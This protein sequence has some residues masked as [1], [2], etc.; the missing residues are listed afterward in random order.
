MCCVLFVLFVF[1]NIRQ[2]GLALTVKLLPSVE[3]L[4]DVLLHDAVY[5]GEVIVEPRHVVPALRIEILFSFPLD[6]LG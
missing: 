6:H 1:K 5:V 3:H 4:L 2:A